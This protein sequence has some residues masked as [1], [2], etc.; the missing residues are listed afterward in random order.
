MRWQWGLNTNR[1]R[2]LDTG[3][4]ISAETV[5]GLV[6]ERQRITGS[7]SDGLAELLRGG[8]LNTRDWETGMREAIKDEYIQQYLLGRG[9]LSQMTQADWGSIGG[10]VADQYRYLGGF[11]RE[12]AAGNLTEAQV[13]ARS[14]MYINSGREAFE[15]ASGRA[16]AEADEA[17]WLLRPADHCSDCIT[18]A[19]LG[20]QPREPWPFTVGKSEAIPC[21]GAT[22]CLTNCQC[23][24][25][26]RVSEEAE[27]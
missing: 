10:M 1:Y 20:W 21:N 16:N 22:Q 25:D 11:A 3:R 19:G 14:R 23:T 7:G 26:Y 8:Q 13:A 2:D 6:D 18:L 24:I 4:F 27:D 15:R 12:V 5:R 9:G 17:I